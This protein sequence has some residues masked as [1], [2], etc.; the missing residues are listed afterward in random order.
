[1]TMNTRKPTILERLAAGTYHSR[2]VLTGLVIPLVWLVFEG[3]SPLFWGMVVGILALASL[4]T[5]HGLRHKRPG[6]TIELANYPCPRIR[7]EGFGLLPTED[8]MRAA[9][10]THCELW[11]R[12]LALL[13][14][15]PEMQLASLTIR[16]VEDVGL[17][18]G[19]TRDVD[20][21]ARYL[22]LPVHRIEIE[23]SLVQS[24]STLLYELGHIPMMS[25]VSHL[26]PNLPKWGEGD[27]VETE[28]AWANWRKKRGL[29]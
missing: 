26:D 29:L 23:D 2:W 24:T 3:V 9:L 20:P 7:V 18:E 1:M 22:P 27:P 13:M 16:Y 21:S 15:I 6:Y 11:R 28:S 5:A 12:P 4:V 19:D 14:A 25:V 10:R 8:S 17:E